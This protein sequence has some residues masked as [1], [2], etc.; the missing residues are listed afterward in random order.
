MVDLSHSGPWWL[1]KCLAGINTYIYN[2]SNLKWMCRIFFRKMGT[3]IRMHVKYLRKPI[4]AR[5]LIKRSLWICE[6]S[7]MH[8]SQVNSFYFSFKI[9]QVMSCFHTCKKSLHFYII[10]YFCILVENAIF[11]STMV[12]SLPQC[13]HEGRCGCFFLHL[14]L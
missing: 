11:A 9:I 13:T 6:Y 4:E 14:V 12:W 1:D 8:P 7:I 3:P 2:F 10:S 5:L